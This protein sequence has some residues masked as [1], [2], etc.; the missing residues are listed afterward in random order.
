MKQLISS[1]VVLVQRQMEMKLYLLKERQ[2]MSMCRA[3]PMMMRTTTKT[4]LRL[5]HQS[6][7]LEPSTKVAIMPARRLYQKLAGATVRARTTVTVQRYLLSHLPP[8]VRR[9][10]F[11]AEYTMLTSW[12]TNGSVPITW[13]PSTPAPMRLIVDPMPVVASRKAGRA[14]TS[15]RPTTKKEMRMMAPIP[16]TITIAMT[17]PATT[18]KAWSWTTN[19]RN[20]CLH[21]SVRSRRL[22]FIHVS[23][24]LFRRNEDLATTDRPSFRPMWPGH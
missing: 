5:I 4:K 22:D 19:K 15:L 23:P 12:R 16:A 10:R 17:M 18:T 3:M 2:P 7:T 1:G 24:M 14:I 13:R 6:V 11:P 20:R 9:R 21:Q 8:L